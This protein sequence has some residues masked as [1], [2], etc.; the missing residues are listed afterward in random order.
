M[1]GTLRD[2]IKRRMWWCIGAFVCGWVLIVVGTE[3]ARS[4]PDLPREVLPLGGVLL[5]AG[6]ALAMNFLVKCPKCQARLARTI[7]MPV[8]FSFGS[9]PKIGFCPYCGV[10]LDESLPQTG[11]QAGNPIHPA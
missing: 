9:G 2:Q 8:A 1:N 10:S 6:G 4:F 11:P 7:A 5:F 3:V